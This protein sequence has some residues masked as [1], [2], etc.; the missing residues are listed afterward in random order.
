MLIE[1]WERL[2]GYDKW[3]QTEA[4]IESSDIE[5]KAHYGRDGSVNYSW[6]SGDTITWTDTRGEHQ[7]AD[8]KVDDESPLYQL[9]SGE[10]VKIRY[11][12]AIPN[13]F[14]YRDLLQ[15]KVRRFFLLLFFGAIFCAVLGA[16][17]LLNYWTHQK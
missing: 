10:K 5:R 14:Y 4:K 8:F 1:L 11:N 2:R 15:S 7:T 13:H 17:I 9:V 3:V 12:P 6:A 16:L